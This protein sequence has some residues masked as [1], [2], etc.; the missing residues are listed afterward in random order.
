MHA[1]G[2]GGEEELHLFV[3]GDAAPSEDE[4]VVVEDEVGVGVV[5]LGGA[6]GVVD[7]VC[8]SGWGL[9][10]IAVVGCEDVRVL[11]GIARVRVGGHGHPVGE[12]VPTAGN[13]YDGRVGGL[14]GTVVGGQIEPLRCWRPPIVDGERAGAWRGLGCCSWGRCRLRLAGAASRVCEPDG[15][16][17][18]G[19]DGHKRCGELR[20]EWA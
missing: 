12:S 15:D 20:G 10:G 13:V 6:G 14:A 11:L 5:G 9:P 19:E 17:D 16:A 4:L 7:W 18:G 1:V 3:W 8:Q 2:A